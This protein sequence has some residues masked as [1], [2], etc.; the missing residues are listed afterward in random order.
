MM[1]DAL[2]TIPGWQVSVWVLAISLPAAIHLGLAGHRD[3]AHTSE[4][5]SEGAA[6]GSLR[7]TGTPLARGA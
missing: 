6:P 4:R 7:W 3:R 1:T 2:T 5:A